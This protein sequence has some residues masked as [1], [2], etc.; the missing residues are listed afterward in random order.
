[1]SVKCCKFILNQIAFY[2]SVVRPC[3]SFSIERQK[4]FRDNV[5][6][7]DSKDI[8][9]YFNIRKEYIE[10]FAAGGQPPCY[11]GC[12]LYEPIEH[13]IDISLGF[14]NIIISN[15]SKCSCNC[16][17][18]ECMDPCADETQYKKYLNTRKPYDIKPILE[19]MKNNN[20]IKDG[21]TFLICGG[22]CG[23]Y[24]R[25]E[26]A[27]LLYLT[28]LFKGKINFLTSGIYYSDIIAKS[29]SFPNNLVKISVDAGT[30]EV[31]EKI[32]RVKTFDKVWKNI[33]KYIKAVDGSSYSKE[34][35]S[36][37][38]LKYIIVPGI[39]DTVEEVKAFI[40]KCRQ[41]NCKRV[42]VDVEHSWIAKYKNNP[43]KNNTVKEVMNYFFD[44]LYNDEK[45]SIDCEGVE[46]KWLWDF[47]K[48]K[49]ISPFERAMVK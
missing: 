26:L 33:E 6:D 15:R 49:Y 47:V 28:A 2:Q 19:Y 24:P 4:L 35:Q 14:S 37:V 32:K 3:C 9:S 20:Y 11:N 5:F 18:C 12:T 25:E 16:I 7:G 1:M 38:E 10:A 40:K 48:P 43:E 36:R 23:E 22:D 21:C 44:T 30:K 31:Y 13:D 42:I 27:Y 8:E 17:Y 34:E 29:L 46:G 41:V 45:M 39:N